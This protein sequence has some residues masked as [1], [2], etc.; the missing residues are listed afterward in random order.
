MIV[1]C[2]VNSWLYVSLETRCSSGCASCA[3]ITEARRP[4]IRKKMKA[5]TM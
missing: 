3:R 1:P 4:P 5:V 2:I